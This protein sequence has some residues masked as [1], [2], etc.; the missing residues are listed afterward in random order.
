MPIDRY[1]IKAQEALQSAQGMASK[2][3]HPEL[4]TSHLLAALL[5]QDGGLVP[6]V[7]QKLGIDPAVIKLNVIQQLEKLPTQRGG[8]TH[9]TTEPRRVLQSAKDEAQNL[10]DEYVST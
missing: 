3:G 5:A 4:D 1:T 8:E 6:P 2:S 7:L 10:K 9:M